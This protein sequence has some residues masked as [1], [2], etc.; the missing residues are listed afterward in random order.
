V[1][2]KNNLPRLAIS[3]YFFFSGLVFSSW[4]S[5]IPHI[6]DEFGFNEAEL[7]GILFMLPLGSLAALPISGWLVQKFS[8]RVIGLLSILLYTVLLYGIAAAEQVFQLSFTLFLFGVVGNFCNIALNAQGLSIQE[9]INKPILSSLHAMWSLGAFVAAA[10][11]GWSMKMGYSIDLHFL[12]VAVLASFVALVFVYLFV[13]DDVVDDGR[14]QKIFVLPNRSLLLLGVIC[15]CVAMT[16]GAMADWSSLYYRQVANEMHNVSTA[17]YTAFA[18]CM[19]T[20]R[21]VGDLFIHRFGHSRVLKFN[22]GLILT[23]IVLALTVS[24]PAVVILGFALVGFGVSS[25]IP[26]VYML[27]AKNK[28]MAPAAALAAVSSLGFTGFLIG[29][30][31]IGFIAQLTGLRYALTIVALMGLIVWVLSMR[32]KSSKLS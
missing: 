9:R 25:G 29:P 8:S 17:G 5:R 23:G 26:I 20:G 15:F 6:K 11:S 16:E 14:E 27:S 4:V 12:L 10:I 7:G 2:K 18:F 13:D 1:F 28:T 19:A 21:F 22:G 31:I 32:V 24:I 3:I 30:P